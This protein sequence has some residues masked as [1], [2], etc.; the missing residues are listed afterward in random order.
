MLVPVFFFTDFGKNKIEQLP[1]S[2]TVYEIAPQLKAY[3]PLYGPTYQLSALFSM[4][5]DTPVYKLYGLSRYDFFD[6]LPQ[7]KPEEKIFYVLKYKTTEWPESYDQ[8]S[9]NKVAEFPK[10]DLEVFEFR[11][12]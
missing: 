10:Y 9:K 7:S 3:K 12:E 11:H 6:T 2:L 8:F 1:S 5:T 4:L